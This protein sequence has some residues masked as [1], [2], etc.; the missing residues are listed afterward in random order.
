MKK[1]TKSQ[2]EGIRLVAD[3][4]VIGDIADKVMSKM[5]TP[6]QLSDFKEHMKK[7]CPEPFAA[8]EELTR[9]IKDAR[10]VWKAEL[11]KRGQKA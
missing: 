1:L 7:S 5:M 11:A 9:Q 3:F 8:G 4:L 2:I 10:E 6:Q